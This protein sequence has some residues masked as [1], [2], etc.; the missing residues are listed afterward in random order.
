MASQSPNIFVS[1]RRK[2]WAFTHRLA[3]DLARRIDSNT[4]ATS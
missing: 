4:R 2:S 3:E 1:Y